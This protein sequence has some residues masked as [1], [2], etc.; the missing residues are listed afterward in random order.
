MQ[1]DV[2][3]GIAILLVLFRHQFVSWEDS[4]PFRPIMIFLF[5]IGWTGV[6]LFFVLSGFLIG[7]LLFTEIHR[8]NRLDVRRFLCRRALK[9]WPAYLIFM[10]FVFFRQ[11]HDWGY[12]VAWYSIGPNL[13]HM[14]NYLGSIRIHTWSLAVEE[15]FYLALP[16]VLALLIRRRKP[17]GT[18]PA[19]PILACILIVLCTTMRI[20]FNWHGPYEFTRDVGP[21]HLRI[22]G[23]FFGVL[24]AYLYH[25]KPATLARIGQHPIALL[26]IGLALVLP[27]GLVEYTDHPFIYTIGFTMLY[28]GYGCILIACLY[29]H[30]GQGMLGRLMASR[31]AA[32]LAWIGVF[33]YS[34]YLWFVDAGHD[35]LEAWLLP[36]L[37]TQRPFAFW[38][39]STIAYLITA[40]A[41]GVVAAKIIE[42]PI[43]KLRDR[44]LPGKASA[45]RSGQADVTNAT[46][47]AS[48]LSP[49]PPI[50]ASPRLF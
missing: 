14:Q 41:A 9:I 50:S 18:M 29:S 12:R 40:I 25:M 3:R 39:C 31:P 11:L 5:H 20:V 37:P 47:V 10:A 2:L 22:D 17:G 32:L 28:L 7:G 34:I 27:M 8:T 23:L 45:L 36:H 48:P 46:V 4:G 44:F 13:M 6:D 1:L 49:R 16:L 38:L 43:L 33:S 15:H 21:T 30:P 42:F 24:L 19:I 26:S 35:L